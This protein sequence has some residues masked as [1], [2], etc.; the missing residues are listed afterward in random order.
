MP[1]QTTGFS[2]RGFLQLAGGATAAGL[3]F[4]ACRRTPPDTIYI[5]KGDTAL[6]NN[7]YIMESVFAAVY[8]QANVTPYYGMDRSE[9]QLTADLRDHAVAHKGLLKYLLEMSNS[10]IPEVVTDLNPITF[11][12]RTNVL[13]HAYALEDLAVGAYYGAAKRFTDTN[14]VLTVAKMATVHARHSAY[15]REM[16][17]H[18][19]FSDSTVVNASGLGQALDP[20]TVFNVMKPYLQTKF[21]ITNLP[22]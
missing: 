22:A 20:L 2:R 14:H 11:A 17:T 8:T 7:L 4:A 3:L 15:A 12:D 18:N 21:D 1:R 6:L 9:L 16:L 5:G 13:S 10:A 19:T